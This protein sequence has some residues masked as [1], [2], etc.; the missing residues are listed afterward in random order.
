MG[1]TVT[2]LGKSIGCKDVGKS[3]NIA[4]GW[5]IKVNIKVTCDNNFTSKFIESINKCL[6]ILQK[7]INSQ[8]VFSC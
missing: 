7:S 6:Q 8:F 3:L 4:L 5:Q 1:W 2:V